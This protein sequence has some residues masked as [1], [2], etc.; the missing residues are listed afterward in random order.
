LDWTHYRLL[1]TIGDEEKRRE[2]SERAVSENWTSRRLQDEI[3][4]D[5]L[6]Q[7]YKDEGIEEGAAASHLKTVRGRL[8]TYRL[9]KPALISPVAARFLIDA[10]FNIWREIELKGISAAN[11]DLLVESVRQGESYRFKISD[12]RRSQIY[13]YKALVEKVTDADTIWVQI[14]LGFSTWVRQK[15]RFR[16]INAAEITTVKGQKAKEFVEQT[17]SGVPFVVIKTYSPDKYDR[18]LADIFYLPMSGLRHRGLPYEVSPQTVASDGK[19]LNQ[20]LLDLN[21]ARII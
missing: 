4:L 18:Y 1:I 2:F 6:R 10:G 16:G 7:K 11:Q 20:Q 5:K 3:R 13:T 19:F 14:D 21:L 17:L 8:Y 15:I 9:I 12:A